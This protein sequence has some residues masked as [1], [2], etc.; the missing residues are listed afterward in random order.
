[1]HNTNLNFSSWGNAF[2]FGQTAVSH[3]GVSAAQS[4]H[5]GDSGESWLGSTFVGP[6]RLTYWSKASSE[7]NFDFLDLF[8]NGAMQ[9]NRLSG[10]TDWR[11]FVFNIPP[12][13]N[14][15]AWRY[16]KDPD[17]SRGVDAGWLDD[18]NFA[19]G[20]WL[21]IFGTPMPGQT[22]LLLHGIPGHPYEIQS[23]TN[24]LTWARLMTNTPVDTSTFITDTNAFRFAIF[25]NAK[26]FARYIE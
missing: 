13:T 6:G 10:E 22:Q 14:A 24:L 20:V 12:G 8:L 25:A 5:I 1:M 3:S 16:A 15:V 18:M 11:V 26:R 7:T 2:W 19:S 17:T 23:S 9:P 4:G 21:E